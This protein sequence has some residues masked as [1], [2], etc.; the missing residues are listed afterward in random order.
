[1]GVAYRGGHDVARTERGFAAE[2]VKRIAH[3]ANMRGGETWSKA[4]SHSVA[5]AAWLVSWI[6]V[7]WIVV[8]VFAFAG[9]GLTVGPILLIWI[10]ATIAVVTGA[11]G[12]ATH[13]W[14][15]YRREWESAGSGAP[16][17]RKR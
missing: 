3:T 1:V 12:M 10:G 16:A 7:S 17:D 9:I 6:L 15:D 13:V 8:A 5:R 11:F 4:S 14:S 2:E